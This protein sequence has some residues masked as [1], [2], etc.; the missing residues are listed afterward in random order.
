MAFVHLPFEVDAARW[1]SAQDQDPHI[2]RVRRYVRLGRFPPDN[3]TREV[4][5]YFR[6][7]DAHLIEEQGV[8]FIEGHYKRKPIRQLIVPQSFVHR[9]LEKSHDEG[10]H[11]GEDRT[12][13]TIRVK[14]YWATMFQDV[15]KWCST[16]KVCQQRKHPRE[17]PRAPLQYPP[18]AAQ[19]GQIVSL[20]FV[21]PL[22]ETP[23]GHRCILVITDMYS[24]FAEA[25]PLPNQTAKTTAD[26]LWR[27]YFCRQGLPEILHSDQGRNFE[28]AVIQELCKLLNIH[29]TRTSPYHPSGNGQCERYNK[30]LIEMISMQMEKEDQTDWDQWIPMML[31]A[32]HST[33]HASTGYT[34]FQL[35]M[36][37]Q[38]RTP[39]DTLADTLVETPHK[40]AQAYVKELQS[41]MSDIHRQAQ[42]HLI[43]AMETR[44]HQYDKK[45]N[46]RTYCKGDL[47]LL[48]QLAC[49]PGLKPKLLKERWTGPWEVNQVRGPVNYRITRKVKGGKKER[50]LVHHDRLKPFHPRPGHLSTE[51]PVDK[52]ELEQTMSEEIRR[53]ENLEQRQHQ[54]CDDSSG[55]D[56]DDESESEAG[57][58]LEVEEEPLA[59]EEEERMDNQ[60]ENQMEEPPEPLMGPQGRTWCNVDLANVLPDGRRSNR[61]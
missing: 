47:V 3:E 58:Q 11:L 36:G 13:E 23:K 37:R 61:Q 38:P 5:D 27:G 48:R 59:E 7:R 46:F 31:F 50:I 20:D 26:A 42:S 17:R 14:F 28:S 2:Q 34:P 1:E 19:P 22:P 8:L 21:G 41:Q 16:C 29:K 40:S 10:G 9:V 12:L 24:K 30:T 49:K 55:S 25:L 44:K 6:K 54:E 52:S 57:D 53:K 18:V 60:E 4:K 39:F 35:Q 32:Y 43:K 15:K 45:L 33:V 51:A 56:E